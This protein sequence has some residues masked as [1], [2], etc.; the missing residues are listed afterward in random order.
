MGHGSVFC[1]LERQHFGKSGVALLFSRVHL[2][3]KL[4]KHQLPRL[5]NQ[6]HP[7]LGL[8]IGYDSA[9]PS[10][11]QLL[12][13]PAQGL[14]DADLPL[15]AGICHAHL[16]MHLA[17]MQFCENLAQ[18][19]IFAILIIILALISVG[20]HQHHKRVSSQIKQKQLSAR[21]KCD[22]ASIPLLLPNYLKIRSFYEFAIKT[23]HLD[24]VGL[25]VSN[26]SWHDLIFPVMPFIK[27][28]YNF[29]A[30]EMG[31]MSS[32]LP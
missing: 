11:G 26:L 25:S 16:S 13:N 32:L 5:L 30:F 19:V 3:Q 17:A 27:K 8:I 24:F 22:L 10:T 20:A 4:K 7:R 18:L 12:G 1:Q 23:D 31:L 14:T 21:R 9:I 15:I 2:S 28:E 6:P 29:S